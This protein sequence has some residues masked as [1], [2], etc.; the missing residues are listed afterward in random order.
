MM[1]GT[2]VA[3]VSRFGLLALGL[4]VAGC[5]AG[6]HGSASPGGAPA[7]GCADV[8]AAAVERDDSG[9]YTVTVT[10][11]SADTGWDKYADR[12]EVLAPDG[13]L[14]AARELAHPHVDEQPFTRLQSGVRIPAD[15]SIVTV[16]A[17]DS[18]S[19]FCGAGLEVEVPR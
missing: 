12:W 1:V 7:G 4:I 13:S 3:A 16:R 19:G 5:A 17:R 2:T 18:V 15:V 14:L 10:V 9:T 6:E 11:R 8:V